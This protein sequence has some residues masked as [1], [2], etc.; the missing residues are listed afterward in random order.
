MGKG[1]KGTFLSNRNVIFIVMVVTLVYGF[2]E[3]VY[4]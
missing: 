3:T 2:V 1:Q 4:T